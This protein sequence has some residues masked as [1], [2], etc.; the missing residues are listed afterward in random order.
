[1]IYLDVEALLLLADLAVG[2]QAQ[3][4]DVGLL[5]SAAARPQAGFGDYEAY[6]TLVEKAAALLHSLVG[7]HALIDG[8]KRLAWTATVVFCDLNGTWLDAP[9]D[10]AYDLVIAVA[11]GRLDVPEIAARLQGWSQ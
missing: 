6:P 2:G 10:D 9:E 7:N 11:E 8:N 1:M 3:V 5:A 4:R